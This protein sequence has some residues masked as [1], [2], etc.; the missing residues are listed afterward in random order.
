MP[1]KRFVLGIDASSIA[2]LQSRTARDRAYAHQSN[3][4]EG[5]IPATP[6]WQFST[7]TVLP[8]TPSSGTRLLDN[9][10]IPGEQTQGQAAAPSLTA[11]VPQRLWRPLLPGDGY[12]GGV[13]FLQQ[14]ETVAC[15]RNPLGLARFPGPA[16]RQPWKREA[17]ERTPPQVRR[18]RRGMIAELGTPAR[19]P[20]VRGK[21][22]GRRE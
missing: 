16:L 21:S 8:E 9:T 2:R 11:L 17:R 6:G 1:H 10:S 3:R 12:Y 5:S 22:P 20:Q 13:T 18:E 15:V 4:P 7:L 19:L 14:I